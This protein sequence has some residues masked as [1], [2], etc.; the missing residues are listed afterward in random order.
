MFKLVEMVS[1]ITLNK[2]ELCSNWSKGFRTS[3][4]ELETHLDYG[5]FF[6]FFFQTSLA[7]VKILNFLNKN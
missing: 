1:S 7:W 2:V 4:K 6:F 3:K 5:V